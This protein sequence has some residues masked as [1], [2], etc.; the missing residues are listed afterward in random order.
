MAIRKEHPA[1]AR[2]WRRNA[3]VGAIL[4]MFVA[5]V[6]GITIVK[7][8]SGHLMEAFDHAVRPSL[9]ESEG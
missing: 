5:L 9:L 6:F 1:F 4:G 8:S 7:L 3:L 2:R